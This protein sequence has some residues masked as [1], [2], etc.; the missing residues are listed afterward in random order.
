LLFAEDYE[1]RPELTDVWAACIHVMKVLLHHD[2]LLLR[3]K[4]A[5]QV[6]LGG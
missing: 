5:P 4:S 3:H 2:L 6:Y 1:P